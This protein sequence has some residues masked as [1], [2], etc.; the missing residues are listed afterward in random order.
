[1]P[2]VN[3][4]LFF[5]GNCAEA[6]RFYEK[7]LGGKS[8]LLTYAES[9][10]KEQV[11]PGHDSDKIMHARLELDGGGVLM[12][13]DTPSAEPTPGMNGFR[14]AIEY[15]TLPEAKR[16][17]DA[18][19]KGGSVFLPFAKT[20]WSAGFG[21]VTDSVM[22]RGVPLEPRSSSLASSSR[23]FGRTGLSTWRRESRR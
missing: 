13:S 15:K 19:A 10:V 14:I 2:D 9:P 18:L 17:F 12:A 11:V 16:V 23:P 22:M 5:N 20:F 21:M 8:R 3:A 6:I 1:M 7:T 4:Y